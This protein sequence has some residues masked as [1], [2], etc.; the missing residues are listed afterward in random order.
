MRKERD[1]VRVCFF[2]AISLVLDV[3]R[4]F[5]YVSVCVYR[6]VCEIILV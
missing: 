6:R 4:L 5:S 2:G 3:S 1:V